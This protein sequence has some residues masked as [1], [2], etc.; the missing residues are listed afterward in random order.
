M[1]NGPR[2]PPRRRAGRDHM[3]LSI[4]HILQTSR[5]ADFKFLT[6]SYRAPNH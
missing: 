1:H 6:C 5:G 3:K 2:E 4:D